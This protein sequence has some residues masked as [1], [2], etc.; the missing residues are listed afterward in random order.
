MSE[1][2]HSTDLEGALDDLVTELLGCGAVLSQI[3]SHMVRFEAEGLS[4]PD[5]APIPAVAHGLI[6]GVLTQVRHSH[7][8]RDLKVA[9]A[10]VR[11]TTEAISENLFV[12]DAETCRSWID[13]EHGDG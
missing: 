3:I 7:S 1:H 11:Q 9:A 12:V 8:R 6:R 5:T 10:I 13:S 4:T 2:N